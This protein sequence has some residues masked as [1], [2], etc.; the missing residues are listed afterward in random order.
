MQVLVEKKK[1]GQIAYTDQ[2][3][4]GTKVKKFL[5]ELRQQVR[6]H[7]QSFPREEN[8]Y[9]R[10]KSKKEFLSP[11]LNIN[12][13]FLAYKKK[14]ANSTVIYKNYS[15]VLKEDFLNLRIGRPKSDTCS[16]CDLYQNKIISI[17]LTSPHRKAEIKNLE[18]HHRKAEKAR[19]TM[20]T[21]IANSQTIDSEDN[22][23]SIDLEQVLFI[24]TLTHS[25][26]FYSWTVILF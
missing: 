14:Y 25:D 8:Y 2:R 5:P 15:L 1:M 26:M 22:T 21:D 16:K 17:P 24:P 23:I 13:M 12:C 4:K 10:N 11:D 6:D 7:I 3:G 9:S 19:A 18:L 20:N